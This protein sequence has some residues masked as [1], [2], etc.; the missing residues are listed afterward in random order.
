MSRL[1]IVDLRFPASAL[2]TCGLFLCVA[3]GCGRSGPE[4]VDV[5]GVVTLDGRPLDR[6]TVTFQ[7]PAGRFSVA[8]TDA[9][10]HYRLKF[11]NSKF[12]AIPGTHTVRII[13]KVL[14]QEGV[15][16][17]GR[18]ELLPAKYHENTVLTADVS[19]DNAEINFDLQ[20]K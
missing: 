1:S 8:E 15:P 18:A 17:S 2:A 5:Q 4:L 3:I 7:P 6:A 12:G 20:S 11:T 9:E 13:S 10:G 19:P 14:Y 16:N